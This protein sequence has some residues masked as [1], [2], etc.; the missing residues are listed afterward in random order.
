MNRTIN[1]LYKVFK[2]SY[3]DSDF[4]IITPANYYEFL[5]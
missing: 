1:F 2:A 5:F 3:P 4:K